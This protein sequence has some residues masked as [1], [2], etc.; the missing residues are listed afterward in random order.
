MTVD[1]LFELARHG[2]RRAFARWAEQVHGPVR[3]SVR[4]F[5]RFVDVE[6]VVQETLLR[7]WMLACDERR[8]LEGENASLRFALRVAH[9][10][11][12]EELRR[13]RREPVDGGD[14]PVEPAVDPAPVADPGL[15][16][17]IVECL[18]ALPK[19]PRAALAARLAD[20]GCRPDRDLAGLVGMQPNTFLQNVVRARR[21]VAECLEGKGVLLRGI[22]S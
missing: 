10:V 8:E 18:E 15:R 1:I 21:R 12:L 5:A 20:G 14:A 2:D 9:H 13:V 11:A 16:A 4:R 3:G 7:M 19:Q 6:V 17:A 22:A